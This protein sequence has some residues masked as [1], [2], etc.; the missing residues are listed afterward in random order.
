MSEIDR[1]MGE[2]GFLTNADLFKLSAEAREILSL[3]FTG[4][5]DNVF[6]SRINPIYRV[7]K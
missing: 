6:F 3:L 7:S 2:I 4:I 1:I 5:A